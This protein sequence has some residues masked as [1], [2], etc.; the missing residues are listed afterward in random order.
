MFVE[1]I[2]GDTY[3]KKELPC[4]SEVIPSSNEV[5]PIILAIILNIYHVSCLHSFAE[6]I[7]MYKKNKIQ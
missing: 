7:K 3:L 1:H 6:Q 4:S 5:I 2:K